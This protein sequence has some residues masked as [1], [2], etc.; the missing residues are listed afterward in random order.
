MRRPVGLLLVG[1]LILAGTAPAFAGRKKVR[2]HAKVKQLLPTGA[3]ADVPRGHW[4][5]D[6]VRMAAEA[7]ILGC[8]GF[9]RSRFSGDRVVNRYQMAVITA[10]MIDRA[11]VL[12]ANGKHLTMRDIAMLESLAIEFAVELRLLN[13]K[14]DALQASLHQLRRDVA[15]VRQESLS[16][17]QPTIQRLWP[18]VVSTSKTPERVH[19]E[20]KI[21]ARRIVVQAAVSRVPS[22][23]SKDA[24]ANSPFSIALAAATLVMGVAASSSLRPRIPVPAPIV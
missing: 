4:A 11:G 24:N 14:D 9:G 6:A 10:R 1:C 5:Y 8:T 20:S 15:M 19:D 22:T 17:L 16:N 21:A 23:G 7:G 2:R 12:Q 18:H 13:V 3:F